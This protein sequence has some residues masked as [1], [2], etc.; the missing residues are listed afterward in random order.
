MR[1]T[2]TDLVAPTSEMPNR[3]S[4]RRLPV[5]AEVLPDGVH[6]RV[7]APLRKQVTVVF[8]PSAEHPNVPEP[9]ALT[10]EAGGYFSGLS[11]T[12]RHGMHYR[13]RLD[14]DR[15][16]YADPVSRFQPDGCASPSQIV[17]PGLYQWQQP[18]WPGISIEGQVIYELHIGTLTEQGTWQAAEA[19]LPKIADLGVTVLEIMPVA[20]FPGHFG[21]GYDGVLLFAPTRLYGPPDNFRHFVD[22]AHRLGMGVILD[23][24]YNHFGPAD[25]YLDQFAGN[26]VS[27]RHRTDWGDAINFDG[28]DCAPVREFFLANAGYW[29]DE[30]RLDGLRLDAIQAIMD[31]SPLHI[32]VEMTRHCRKVA[33]NRSVIITAESELQHAELIRPEAD[34]G[35]GLDAAWND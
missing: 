14:D 9:L 16:L 3:S 29:I 18:D 34:G 33:D 32:L 7:W 11:T 2:K 27:S 15:R 21:W 19:C 5:G 25:N 28:Q 35:S 26:F 13:L 22:E 6:F 1:S 23:V 10:S 30:Y 20:E 12:A 4:R 31:D 24:V 17:D 8:E